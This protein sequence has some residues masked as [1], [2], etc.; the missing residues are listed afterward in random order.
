MHMTIGFTRFFCILYH[1]E[2]A[3]LLEESLDEAAEVPV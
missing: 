2:A 1:L 3:G